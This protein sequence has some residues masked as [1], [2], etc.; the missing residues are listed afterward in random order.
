MSIRLKFLLSVLG[1]ILTLVV[2]ASVFTVNSTRSTL[3]NNASDQANA[4]EL[5]VYEL[6]NTTHSIM[7]DRVDG[8]MKV[9]KKRGQALGTAELG[10][11]VQVGDRTV[12]NLLLGGQGQ[13]NRFELVDG[14]TQDMGGT[15]TLFVRAG[16]DFVRVSTNV[17]KGDGSRATGTILT[18]GGA[19]Y[20]QIMAKESF[21]GKIN[22]LGNPYLTGYSPILDNSGDVVG[23][24]YVGY[25]ADMS[26]LETSI[27]GAKVLDNGFVAL[28]DDSG[29]VRMNTESDTVNRDLVTDA[30]QNENADSWSL[31]SRDYEPW[32]Y[33]IVAGISNDEVSEQVL[34]RSLMAAAAI[35]GAGVILMIIIAVLLNLTILKPMQTMVE[36]VEDI[37]EG[38]GDLTVR[39]NY[40]RTDELGRMANGF[41]KLL[42]KLQ[43]TIKD[44]TSASAD[45][46]KESANLAM[47]SD[48]SRLAVENQREQAEQVASAMHEM[49]S[50]AGT[51]SQSAVEA[52]QS[53]REVF[54]QVS[55]G[56]A[57]LRNT[58]KEIGQQGEMI[59]ASV[60]AVQDLKTFS[61]EITTVLTMIND[62]AEQTNLLALNAAIEAARAGEHGRGFSVVADEVRTLATRTQSS[63]TSIQDQ[64]SKLQ[65]GSTLAS[66]KMNMTEALASTISTQS[67][68]CGEMMD[69]ITD[70]MS[71]ISD[72]N[73]EMA[74]AAEQQSQVAEEISKSV[75]H[76]K[77]STDVA[78]EQASKTSE[79]SKQLKELADQLKKNMDAYVV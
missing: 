27:A 75:M 52:E 42:A 4:A 58:I 30:L 24:W 46:S 26:V 8:S 19:A 57:L 41:D 22:I 54:A 56:Q 48:D 15:A 62:I 20:N 3:V 67:K 10:G 43:K 66:D 21:F 49:A 63:V 18:P 68:E 73:T 1:V 44:V 16:Q 13:A 25:S 45:L 9:L 5:A 59:S 71:A 61:N 38:E 78:T 60:K 65:D 50:T 29:E 32:G 34:S 17:K 40:T 53:A 51:V 36:A 77:E 64:V 55:E 28:I 12:P 69:R 33:Q 6:L 14:L 76:I 70:S 7:M 2:L 11:N 79:A 31:I 23:I 39:F 35:L 37:A 74:S 47:V 72:K